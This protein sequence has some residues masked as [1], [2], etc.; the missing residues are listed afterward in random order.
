MSN[1]VQPLIDLYKN[2]IRSYRNC[3]PYKLVQPV[4]AQGCVSLEDEYQW[5]QE[6]RWDLEKESDS[7]PPYLAELP[8]YICCHDGDSEKIRKKY[9][10]AREALF[11][12]LY[13]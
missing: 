2:V 10:A 8:T 1:R 4:L 7:Q 9:Q 3:A 6:I 11:K 5:I 13:P 12:L